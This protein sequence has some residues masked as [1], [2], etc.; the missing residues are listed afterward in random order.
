MANI[1]S[2]QEQITPAN[3]AHVVKDSANANAGSVYKTQSYPAEYNRDR[4]TSRNDENSVGNQDQTTE[5]PIR[6]WSN[7]PDF[8]GYRSKVHYKMV[9]H[10]QRTKK[11]KYR[12]APTY[13]YTLKGRCPRF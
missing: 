5:A 13:N 2:A 8:L 12:P 7:P 4:I 11:H 3:K 1:L 6:D 9:K 10:K